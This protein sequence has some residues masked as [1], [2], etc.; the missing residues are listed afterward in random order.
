MTRHQKVAHDQPLN[1]PREEDTDADADRISWALS[2]PKNNLPSNYFSGN[3]SMLQE[4]VAAWNDLFKRDR[5][6]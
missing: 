1:A 4:L 6:S 3:Q 5:P 2:Y